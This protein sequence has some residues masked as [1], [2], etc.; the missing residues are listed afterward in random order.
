MYSVNPDEGRTTRR[1]AGA[2]VKG[3]ILILALV[4]AW[5]LMTGEPPPGLTPGG[6]RALGVAWLALVLWVLSPIPLGATGLL[7][8]VLLPALG[9]IEQQRAFSYFGNSAVFFLLGVFILT[10]AL[11]RTGLSKRLALLFLSRIGTGPRRLTLGVMFLC[12]FMA[13]WMPEHAV[14]AMAYPVVL[15]IVRSLG[16]R[17]GGSRFGTGIFL[18]LAWGA[19][20]GGVGTLLGGARAPLAL[21]IATQLGA[22]RISFATWALAAVPISLLVTLA[23]FLI[24]RLLF[25]P[26]IESVEPARRILAD[27][28]ALIGRMRSV[29]WRVGLL[30]IA[31]ILLWIIQ[32]EKVGLAVIAV[33]A[34]VAVFLLRI[35]S[36]SE[37]VD[38]VNW[39]VI[40]MYGGAIAL[41]RALLE[42]GAVAFLAETLTRRLGLALAGSDLFFSGL[43]LLL[44]QGI[45]NAA[46]VVVV[47]PMGLGFVGVEGLAAARLTIIVAVAAGFA[48]CFPV[49]T[50]ANAIIHDSGFVKIK[51][52]AGAGVLATIAAWIIL[53]LAVKFYWPHLVGFF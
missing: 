39:N 44:S 15:E 9:I 14:A 5:L 38:Y 7:A 25:P 29:E 32:G 2:W 3:A 27:E 46:A 12:A 1:P 45:S 47:L 28:L 19:I 53:S 6:M 35:A 10:G 4:P 51:Q 30:L 36:W 17:E 8:I 37:V 23:G 21:E 50:P 24:L 26:E 22:A 34:A 41:G 16:L 18:A 11:I 42:T 48:F 40:V 49:S 31:C 33:G 43:A 13:F 52:M 20:A